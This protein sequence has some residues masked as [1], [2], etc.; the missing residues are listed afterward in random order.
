MK[1]RVLAATALSLSITLGAAQAQ[2]TQEP[3]S[4]RGMGSFHVGGKLV[5][6]SGRPVTEVTFSPGGV[7]AKVDP[8]GTYQ[9]GQMYVQYFLPQNEKGSVPL[10]FWHGGGMTGVNYESTPDG[11]QGWLEFFL[12]KGWSVYNS[13]AVERGRSSWAMYP[14]VIPGQPVFLTTANPFERFRIG[15]GANS[16]NA[17]PAK[18]KYL[19]GNQFPPDGYDNFVKQIVPRWTSTDDMIIDA[20]LA[21][22]DKVC[23]CVIMFHSQAGQFGFKVAQARPDKVKAL[24]AIEPAGIGD[25][26][27]AAALKDIPVLMVFG[28]FI[29]QDSRWPTIRKNATDF[30]DKIT[31]AGGSVDVVNLPAV[32]IKGNSHMMMMDKNNL[33]VSQLVQT[34]LE[35]KKLTK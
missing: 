9:T 25:P 14:D 15:D 24:V 29:E 1:F 5:E 17:D 31:A 19:P 16:Y 4:L 27:K 26:T 13:D 33:E 10:L 32:G 2:Q 6:L 23:P 34:W 35:K 21:E 11:R 20:Y 8:N 22:V 12:R 18:R 7:P 28:D 30:G 3:I